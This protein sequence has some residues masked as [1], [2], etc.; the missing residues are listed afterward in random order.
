MRGHAG[1]C[2]EVEAGKAAMQDF[3]VFHVLARLVGPRESRLKGLVVVFGA[4]RRVGHRAL[5]ASNVD[6][7]IHVFSA[8]ELAGPR[9][10]G[11]FLSCA[12]GREEVV[13]GQVR[14][15]VVQRI[16]LAQFF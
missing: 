9:M 5:C 11:V 3:V 1:Q 2:K 16:V 12:R 10:Q 7:A 4:G 13:F 14:K 8:D 6:L 15:D